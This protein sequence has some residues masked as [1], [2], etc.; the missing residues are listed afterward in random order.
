[1]C[2]FVIDLAMS[3]KLKMKLPG[4]YNNVFKNLYML[5]TFTSVKIFVKYLRKIRIQVDQVQLI[6]DFRNI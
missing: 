4:I 2:L 3:L 1:M 5:V 6:T